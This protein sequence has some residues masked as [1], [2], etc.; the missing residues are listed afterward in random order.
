MVRAQIQF[1]E[2]QHQRVRQLAHR[3]RI[4]VSEAVRRLVAVGLRVGIDGEQ[5]LRAAA[6]LEVAGIGDS[7]LGALGR[8]HADYLDGDLTP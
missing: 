1:E 7:G 2:R 6:L 3:R 5:P 4:S 8:R